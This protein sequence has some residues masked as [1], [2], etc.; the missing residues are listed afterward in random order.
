[1]REGDTNTYNKHIS[2]Q[3]F[4]TVLSLIYS[5]DIVMRCKLCIMGMD[6]ESR[7]QDEKWKFYGNIMIFTK[8]LQPRLTTDQK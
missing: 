6:N 8:T 2:K 4:Y 1:M 5:I 7:W 3:Y